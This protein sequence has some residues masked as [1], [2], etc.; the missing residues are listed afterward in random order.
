VRYVLVRVR[1]TL[2]AVLAAEKKVVVHEKLIGK[3]EGAF[4][5]NIQ[6][7]DDSA[8]AFAG[9]VAKLSKEEV[10]IAEQVP[11]E[12]TTGV[13]GVF[14]QLLSLQK[15]AFDF[16]QKG[17]LPFVNDMTEVLRNTEPLAPLMKGL[18]SGFQRVHVAFMQMKSAAASIT[19]TSLT[20]ERE[21]N[22]L[23]SSVENVAMKEEADRLKLT[24]DAMRALQTSRNQTE[25]VIAVLSR[26]TETTK[27]SERKLLDELTR[28]LHAIVNNKTRLDAKFQKHAQQFSTEIGKAQGALEQARRAT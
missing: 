5:K 10:G 13:G 25:E 14:T 9:S 23:S 11:V 19:S 1:Q 2:K 28:A 17:T 22:Q 26:V 20:D 18:H 16:H 7:L 6:K 21:A 8:S 3:F 27:N 4:P 15:N 12:A 24:Q